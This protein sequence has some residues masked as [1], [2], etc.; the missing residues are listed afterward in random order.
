MKSTED[1]DVDGDFI[2][3]V[4]SSYKYDI[5]EALKWH[6]G[7]ENLDFPSGRLFRYNQ[8]NDKLELLLQNLYYPNGVLLIK[9]KN[10]QALL[11]NEFSMGRI[12]KLAFNSLYF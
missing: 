3:F 12:I 7:N 1:L 5:N 6:E 10:E 11:I 2:Y 4:D 8:K 9:A